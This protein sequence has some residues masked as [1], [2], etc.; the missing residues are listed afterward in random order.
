MTCAT[1]LADTLQESELLALPAEEI[2]TRLFHEETVRVF[3]PRPVTHDWPMDW[4]K[5][6]AMLRG[7]GQAEIE[8]ILSE[9]GEVAVHDDL[10]NHSYRF[11]AADIAELFA[12]PSPPTVH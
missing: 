7:L 10:S 4:E 11:S 8:A 12:P 9:H 5:I 2:L 6:R 3:E 1:G